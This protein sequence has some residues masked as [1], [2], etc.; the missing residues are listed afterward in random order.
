MVTWWALHL[1]LPAAR[2]EALGREL[3]AKSSECLALGK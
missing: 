2:T 1:V 3:R